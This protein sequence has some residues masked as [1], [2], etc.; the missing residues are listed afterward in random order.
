MRIHPAVTLSDA[1]RAAV[2]ARVQHFMATFPAP[3][4]VITRGLDGQPRHRLMGVRT[5]GFW[6]YLITVKPS[7]K[8]AELEADPRIQ[9][10]WYQYDAHDPGQD[11]P[12]RYV[13]VTGIAELVSTADGMRSLPENDPAKL[14]HERE[15]RSVNP[16]NITEL[17]DQTLESSRLGIIVRPVRIR[18]EGFVPGPR[19]PMY[20]HGDE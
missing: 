10:V 2:K 5:R 1:E 16:P 14:E 4:I 11:Q 3:K 7:T 13:A 8:I 20:F 12:L 19:Y 17:D 15:W 9:I 6:C 18:V